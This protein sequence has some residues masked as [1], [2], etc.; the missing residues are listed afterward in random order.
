[1]AYFNVFLDF[2]YWKILMYKKVGKVW[3]NWIMS[4]SVEKGLENVRKTAKS[5]VIII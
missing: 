4:G 2:V 5:N 1:M 3:K